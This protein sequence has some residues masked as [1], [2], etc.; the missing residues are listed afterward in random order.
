MPDGTSVSLEA[1]TG[2]K[3]GKHKFMLRKELILINP[4]DKTVAGIAGSIVAESFLGG[5]NRYVI[6]AGGVEIIAVGD[7]N[8]SRV[9]DQNVR[10]GWCSSDLLLLDEPANV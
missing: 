3:P 2:L 9:N 1:S 5:I 6:Q 8:N 7:A 10:I 4:P